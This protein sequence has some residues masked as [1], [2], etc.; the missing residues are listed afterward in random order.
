[1]VQTVFLIR[2]GDY[3]NPKTYDLFDTLSLTACFSVEGVSWCCMAT[4]ARL[5]KY[6]SLGEISLK[7]LEP[8][9]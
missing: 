8:L 7:C 4:S 6:S 3:I 1:M 5:M 9:Q 2:F